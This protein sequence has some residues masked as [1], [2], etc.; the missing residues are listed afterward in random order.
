MQ[1][2]Q[3][4]K[5]SLEMYEREVG[6]KQR[7]T[8]TM[9]TVNEGEAI[10]KLFDQDA[11]RSKMSKE[12]LKLKHKEWNQWNPPRVSKL[13][14][15]DFYHMHF[16][17][18]FFQDDKKKR[19]PKANREFSHVASRYKVANSPSKLKLANRLQPKSVGMVNS[20]SG[21]DYPRHEVA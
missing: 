4:L 3:Y 10:N 5:K 20:G 2:S 21:P 9:S 6:S 19:L 13:K 14:K 12:S 15:K 8:Y 7:M 17:V 1:L 18:Q 11:I 16:D